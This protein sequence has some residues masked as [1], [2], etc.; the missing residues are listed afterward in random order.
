MRKQR[1]VI[2]TL[3]ILLLAGSWIFY[4]KANGNLFRK[5]PSFFEY[6]VYEYEDTG[7]IVKQVNCFPGPATFYNSY[8]AYCHSDYKQWI[9]DNC[10][11]EFTFSF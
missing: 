11:N 4:A 7:Q 10:G 9:Q 2:A 1:I 6:K 5:C 8:R 3:V